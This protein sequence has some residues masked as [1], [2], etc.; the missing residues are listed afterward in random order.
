MEFRISLFQAGL[1]H[2]VEIGAVGFC[3][4]FGD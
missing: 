3:V 1:P 4:D 2:A